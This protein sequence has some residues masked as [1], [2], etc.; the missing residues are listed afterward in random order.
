MV[1]DYDEDDFMLSASEEEHP[2]ESTRRQASAE[3]GEGSG[4]EMLGMYSKRAR[5]LKHQDSEL[6]E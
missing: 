4:D 1:M 2:K 5:G 3:G 6:M